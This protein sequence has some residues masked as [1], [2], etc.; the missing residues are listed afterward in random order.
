MHKQ[1]L[2]K[3][4]V[5]IVWLG[6]TATISLIA[7]AIASSPWFSFQ[8]NWLSDLGNSTMSKNYVGGIWVK[9]V[10][11]ASLMIGGIAG[12]CFSYILFI[13]NT[14]STKNGKIA[15]FLFFMGMIFIFLT[16]LFSEDFGIIHTIVSLCL[17]FLVPI[18]LLAF[19][20][21]LESWEKR[22]FQIIAISSLVAFIFLFVD[23]PW[24]SNALVE[25]IPCAALGIGLI[26][27]TKKMLAESQREDPT[28]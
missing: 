17:F 16:G 28:P 4:G 2:L 12:M 26:I 6:Y 1:N 18:S 9:Y 15:V 24:G 21:S 19:S 7:V 14:F 13:S 3:L 20:V 11:D 8:Y 10:F 25:L 27:L 22:L 5:V 23:R